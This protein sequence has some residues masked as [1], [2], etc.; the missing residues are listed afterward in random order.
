MGQVLIGE[1]EGCIQVHENLIGG[2]RMVGEIGRVE[3]GESIQAYRSNF[4]KYRPVKQFCKG[5]SSSSRKYGK[6]KFCKTKCPIAEAL[7]KGSVLMT[8]R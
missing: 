4:I 1:R 7:F 3:K 6:V 5:C 8:L 2:M